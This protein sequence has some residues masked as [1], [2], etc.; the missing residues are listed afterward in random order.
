MWQK[1]PLI[2]IIKWGNKLHLIILLTETWLITNDMIYLN[3]YNK[4]SRYG[5]RNNGHG[6][7]SIFKKYT[8][9]KTDFEAANN[10]DDLL[11]CN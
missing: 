4:A 3:N 2:I 8:K 5:R 10:S 7:I 1:T 6:G 11:H 9:N